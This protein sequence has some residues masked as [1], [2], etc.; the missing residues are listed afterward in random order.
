MRRALLRWPGA[1]SLRLALWFALASVLVLGAIGVYLYQS[2]AREIAWR[3]DSALA[4]RVERIRALLDDSS[5]DA[6][7]SRPQLYANMLGSR[8]SVLWLIDASGR[9][10]IEVNPARLPLPQLAPSRSIALAD[11]DAGPATRLA[12]VDLEQGGRTLR[13]VAG[14][15]LAERAQMMAS[16]QLKLVAALALGAL[17]TFALGWLISQRGLRPVRQLAARAAAIDVQRLHVRLADQVSDLPPSH[18]LRGLTLALDQMLERLA[19]GYTQLSRFSEDLAHELRTPLSNLMGHTQQTLGKVRSVAEYQDLLASNQEEYERLA[20]MIDSMLFLARS[21][22]RSTALQREPIALA[23]MAAQLADYFDGM[24][25]ERGMTFALQASGT[26]LADRQ[27]L[28]RAM[29]N[30]LANALRYGAAGSTVTISAQTLAGVVELAVHNSGPAIDAQHLPHL[31]ERFYRCD[32]ARSKPD[33][34]G[35]L[36]LAIVRSIMQLH[37]GTASVRSGVDSTCFTLSFPQ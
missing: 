8:D 5:I 33:D 34:S 4:G 17:L 12:W 21:A 26:L 1:I 18:E 27:L 29:A 22:H 36:G 3:D 23:D 9:A 14:K 24:A 37:G 25:E 35:G 28:Q 32:P 15:V 2:L 11:A 7:R 30:L 16:Y 19:D 20:R 10:L 6:L 31:F 13:L